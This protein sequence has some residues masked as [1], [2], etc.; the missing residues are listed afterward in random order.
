MGQHE[1][2]PALKSVPEVNLNCF[3]IVKQIGKGSYGKVWK[4][5]NKKNNK[6]RNKNNF[7]KIKI[8]VMIQ[9]NYLILVLIILVLV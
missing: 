4:V 1:V 6:I 5:I 3:R 7:L 9:V 8:L 2:N